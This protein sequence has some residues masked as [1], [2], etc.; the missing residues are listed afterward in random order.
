MVAVGATLAARRFKSEQCATEPAAML[1]Q[2]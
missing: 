1:H 2:K